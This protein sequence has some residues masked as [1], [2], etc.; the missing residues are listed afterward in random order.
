MTEMEIKAIILDFGQV[1]NAPIDP[2]LTGK[3]R[4]RLASR[5]DL[6]TEELWPYVFEGEPSKRWMT[7][8]LDWNGFWTAVLSPKGITDPPEIE[9]FAQEITAEDN[10]VH[11]EMLEL[12]HQLRGRFKLAVLSNAT[13]TEEKMKEMFEN[14]M[15]L[16][17]DLFD[18][19]VTSTSVGVTKPH[20]KIYHEV[21][22][23]LGVHPGEA[24]FT[25]DVAAYTLAAAE[26]GMHAHHFSTPSN[27][28]DYLVGMDILDQQ[29]P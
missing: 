12:I 1:L 23:R 24:I 29:K 18:T 4:K 6:R 8:K 26:L 28:R 15:S 11:P 13:W 16:P 22:G 21:L 2:L 9:S 3:K 17:V 27:F 20:P 10:I 14:D 7:G 5:L 25:D 19:I